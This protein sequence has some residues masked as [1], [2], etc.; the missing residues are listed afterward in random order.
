[1]KP[2]VVPFD[3]STV[4]VEAPAIPPGVIRRWAVSGAIPTSDTP[5]AA[6]P[7][8]EALG[9]LQ[10][11]DARPT[12]LLELHRFVT[13]C[14]RAVAKAPASRACVRAAGRRLVPFD[15]GFSDRATVFVNGRPLFYSDQS[16]RF[17]APRREGLIGFDQARVWLPLEAGENELAVLVSGQL[18]RLGPHG[19][20]RGCVGA[21]DRPALTGRVKGGDR[22]A[23]V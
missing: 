10:A 3:F 7:S 23:A 19:P 21:G 2:N 16:Y 17:D 13:R 1:M 8:A 6:L 9:K 14:P 4:A 12:G 15:L 22:Q 11:V 18:R 20:L 5:P